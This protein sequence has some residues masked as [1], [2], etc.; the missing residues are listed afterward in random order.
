M[1]KFR[2]VLASVLGVSLLWTGGTPAEAA[3]DTAPP[4]VVTFDFT[5]K[6]VDVS[7]G[8]QQ[9]TVTAQITDASGVEAPRVRV[10]SDST[11]QASEYADLTLTAG[12]AKNGIY[13]ATVTVPAG[14]AAGAWSV[15]IDPLADVLGN[16][17]GAKSTHAKKLAVLDDNADLNPPALVDYTFSPSTVDVSSGPQ[18]VTISARITDA[19]GTVPPHVTVTSDRSTQSVG[20]LDLVLTGG[21]AR[22]GTYEATATILA[23][24]T[25]GAW[26]V[27]LD[28]LADTLGNR[29]LSH[30]R[31]ASSLTVLD[32]HPDPDPP[33]LED[34]TFTP[35]TV[36]V[37]AGSQQVD[38]TAHISDATGAVAPTVY[39]DSDT[40]NQVVGPI[41]L[42]RTS[43]DAK[44]GIYGASATV[45]VTA[46]AGTWAVVLSPLVDL[47]GNREPSEHTHWAR[48]TVRNEPVSVPDPPTAVT[49][50]R[51]DRSAQVSWTPGND[52]GS[53]VTSFTITASPGGATKQAT[54]NQTSTLFT[55][56]TNGTAYTFTVTATNAN[57]TSKPSLASTAVTPAAIP[58]PPTA[59]T[60][61]R[62][63]K[64]A[65]VSWTPGSNNGYPISGYTITTLPGGVVKT[66]TGTMTTTSIAG[67]TNGTPYTFT[68]AATNANG[69]SL[70]S[71]QSTAVTPAGVPTAPTAVSAVRGDKF[72]QVTWT[73]SADNGSAITGFTVTASPG[74]A[75]MSVS[76]EKTSATLINLSNGVP[77]TFT[78]KA[79]NAVGTSTA[80]TPSPAVTPATLPSAPAGVIAK[81]GDKSAIVT[82][83]PAVD[84][85]APITGYTITASPGGATVVLTGTKTSTTLKDLINGLSYTFTVTATNAVG[86]SPSSPASAAITPATVPSP[87]IGLIATR[88]DKSAQVTWTPSADNGSP[89]TAYTI[90]A[91]PGGATTTVAGT[92]TT[93]KILGLV[94]GSTYTFTVKAINALGSSAASPPSAAVVPA[95][96]PGTPTEVT[97]TRGPR[98]AAISW[99]AP[100]DN[101]SPITG[102]TITINPGGTTATVAGTQTRTTIKGLANGTSYT[103]TV[104]ATNT[105]GASPESLSSQSVI[106]AGRPR[107]VETPTA[108]VDKRTVTISWSAPEDNGA[109]LT[110]YIVNVDPGRAYK[111]VLP[112][113]LTATF[114]GLNPGTYRFSVVATNYLGSGKKSPK[115]TVRVRG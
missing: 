100:A 73:P 113:T 25:A 39:L 40:T 11:S 87:P 8:D 63:D 67:L 24:A 42:T 34:Y 26:T 66:V 75:S 30:H 108:T 72:A 81:G 82:W 13:A 20:T 9:V 102:Y 68:V 101:G 38:V 111:T 23:G 46:A 51:S 103:F 43:G 31:H 62:G 86:T 33:V 106:P 54:S 76:A 109:P 5:P 91:S 78:V 110:S 95:T 19:T 79:I 27:T 49:A 17:S 98:S 14:A 28:P 32:L 59:V 56:L 69:T 29:E 83:T 45:P 96:V 115:I 85:G 60:A 2:L 70:P 57:G 16:V 36:D 88:G 114:V 65:Q 64:T 44:A 6:T 3:T 37:G 22:D 12:D 112:T 15:S 92:L 71:L 105:V 52:H 1:S 55:G 94:N 84:N 53:Q 77:Y 61:T 50:L 10:T 21:D 107:R 93:A 41:T 48:L 90:T 80:S 4:T 47:L 18:L 89:I 58:A 97:A 35:T 99:R 104:S 74:G 7:A